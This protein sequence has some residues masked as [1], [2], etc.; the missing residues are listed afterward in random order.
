MS[1]DELT[2]LHALPPRPGARRPRLTK[3]FWSDGS[4][5]DYDRGASLFRAEVVSLTG[6][7]DLFR[8]LCALRRNPHACIVRGALSAEANPARIQRR[9][10]KPPHDLLDA[11]RRWMALDID[12][13][14]RPRRLKSA[15]MLELADWLIAQLPAEIGRASCV[16]QWSASMGL[17]EDGAIRAHLW[18]WLSEPVSNGALRA[19]VGMLRDKGHKWLDVAL[20]NP[21]QPHFVADPILSGLEDPVQKRVEPWWSVEGVHELDLTR[22]EAEWAA[23]QQARRLRL[24]RPTATPSEDAW[25]FS[26]A[27]DAL[28]FI[29]PDCEYSR[30]LAV[31]MALN[32]RWPCDAGLSLWDAFS[33][34]GAKYEQGLCDYKWRSFSPIEGGVELATLFDLAKAGGWKHPGREPARGPEARVSEPY[35]FDPGEPPAYLIDPPSTRKER[36]APPSAP[37]PEE[38][39]SDPEQRWGRRYRQTDNDNA[40]RLV[41]AHGAILR[42]VPVFKDW[43]V[44]DG[45]CW[46]VDRKETVQEISKEVT[47]EL[48]REAEALELDHPARKGALRFAARSAGERPIGAMARLARSDPRIV[49][50]PEDL[51]RHDWWLGCQGSTVD[52]RTGQRWDP[53]PTDHL[54]RACRAPYDPEAS[55]PTWERFLLDVMNESAEMVAFLHRAIGYSL[56][57]RT[58]EQV[59]F[60]CHGVGRNGKSTLLETIAW[61]LG[62]YAQT[63]RFSTFLEQRGDNIRDDIADL[64]GARFVSAVEPKPERGFD[65]GAVKHLTGGDTVRAR[66]LYARSFEF[67]PVFTLWLGTNHLPRV[68]GT[69]EGIWRRL[70]PIPFLVNF[71]GREQ[72]DLKDRLKAEAPGILAWA[73]R[74]CMAWQQ[75][76]LDP[77]EAVKTAKNEYR[78]AMDQL[79]EFI[80]ECCV[81]GPTFRARTNTLADAFERFVGHRVNRAR[82]AAQMEAKGIGRLKSGGHHYFAGIG[83]LADEDE[84]R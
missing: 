59:L 62:D 51:D 53:R 33:A 70:M 73:V 71:E 23:A 45:D 1:S 69:D 56:T 35:A 26:L 61:V 14:P 49:L 4:V 82:L 34:A 52:L 41:D 72:K 31:G 84:R 10:R 44:W 30:W 25:D 76:G 27:R 74:G 24:E 21:V 48:W 78:Q 29:D 6:I 19:F 46:R 11:P 12:G 80:E 15:S 57:A 58:D 13:L 65:E 16:V 77:P 64:R 37:P 40:R 81:L 22:I 8:H 36:P 50:L 7:G 83:L 54:T 17:V 47:E 39:G 63:A 68:R 28:D 67:A 75:I 2:I 43:Y 55:C 38:D 20:Y 32:A 3:A 42:Y 60:L 9:F 5:Q 79:S 18:F 66:H